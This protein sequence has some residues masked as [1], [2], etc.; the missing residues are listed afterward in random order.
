MSLRNDRISAGVAYHAR[1]S[2][3]EPAGPER[4][5]GP[6]WRAERWIQFAAGLGIPVQSIHWDS[7]ADSSAGELPSTGV[8]V[9]GERCFGSVD[10]SLVDHARR[11]A[12]A[13]EWA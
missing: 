1:V 8:T 12:A 6:A 3:A 13:M 2:D 11:L 7:R 10:V 9:V 4:L 5:C